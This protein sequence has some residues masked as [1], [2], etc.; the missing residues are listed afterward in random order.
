M[1]SSNLCGALVRKNFL[2][3]I[4]DD[5]RAELPPLHN[6]VHAPNLA[7][8]SADGLSFDR[9]YCNQPVW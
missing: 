9:A 7:K 3:I 2:Y 8:L 6:G 4:S 1:N 5:L